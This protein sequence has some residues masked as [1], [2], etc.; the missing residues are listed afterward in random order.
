MNH[1]TEAVRL[2][3]KQEGDKREFAEHAALSGK[4]AAHIAQA[5]RDQGG[6]CSNSQVEKHIN[7]FV[8]I[9]GCVLN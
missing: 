9:I 5:I 1:V 2:W 7:A 3:K 8:C 4:P 6:D